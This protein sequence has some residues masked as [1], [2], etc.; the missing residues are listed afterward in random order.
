MNVGIVGL[1]TN[2]VD[3][4][5][6]DQDE[7]ARLGH[8]TSTMSDRHKKAH[9]ARCERYTW[10]GFSVGAKRLFTDS[11]YFIRPAYEAPDA[12]SCLC[13]SQARHQQIVLFGDIYKLQG[14]DGKTP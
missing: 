4:V 7:T 11:W 10:H 1:V 5:V 14:F 9:K 6:P 8:K 2:I 12:L 13:W 3:N